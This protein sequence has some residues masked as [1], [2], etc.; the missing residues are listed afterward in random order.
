MRATFI[1]QFVALAQI[2]TCP[3]DLDDE[4]CLLQQRSFLEQKLQAQ[5][6][7]F[8]MGDSGASLGGAPDGLS[9]DEMWAWFE[10]AI[11]GKTTEECP[12]KV[13]E[14]NSE[15][16]KCVFVGAEML[17]TKRLVEPKVTLVDWFGDN[18][19]IKELKYSYTN[20]LGEVV[21]L[22]NPSVESHKWPVGNNTV[23][24]TG[25]D[26]SGNTAKCHRTVWIHDIEK[27]EFVTSTSDVDNRFTL[28]LDG[29]CTLT[30][31]QVFSGYESLGWEPAA[32][33]NCHSAHV[34]I[35]L[36]DKS[37]QTI[38]DSGDPEYAGVS[39]ESVALG[40]GPGNYEVIY[41]A[42]DMHSNINEWKVGFEALDNT[43]P[44][45]F[46]GCPADMEFI[47]EAHVDTVVV[48]WTPPFVSKDNCLEYGT[49]P[50][51]VEQSVP[52]KHPGDE[53][54]VGV[55]DVKYALEDASGN[56]MD[57]E[58]TFTIT[59]KQKAHLVELTCPPSVQV[60]TVTDAGFG[61]PT[62]SPP[63]AM[64]G[65]KQLDAS[66]VK[67]FH[68]V[69]SGMPFPYGVTIVKV[70][71]TGEVTGERVEEAER[72]AE[73]EFNVTVL[74][75]QDPEVDGRLYRCEQPVTSH[76]VDPFGVCNGK[77]LAVHLHHGYEQ[78]GA[79]DIMGTITLADGICCN[80]ELGEAHTCQGT[81]GSSTVSYCAPK[82]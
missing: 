76:S 58:C 79:Y 8:G 13:F 7:P 25:Y 31:A 71:A 43:N 32:T 57:A 19:L 82:P 10:K 69:E 41:T 38:Y 53:F 66:H 80:N 5:T 44:S 56:S 36:K 18:V 22:I 16:G 75:P 29:N 35:A 64:Q 24:V 27:P 70:N 37:G 3:D 9:A 78:T 62:W 40:E 30:A 15:P 61:L 52:K 55:H 48:D 34:E 54:G 63:V 2:E 59:V 6:D 49:F 21:Q 42:Y 12:G 1:L 73:C 60:S 72:Y 39:P 65:P 68:G 47:L 45:E 14:A 33:D 20:P 81:P 67:I 74:D 77:K 17:Y 26:L 46:S 11:M 28:D 51:A 23:V 4:V 50:D